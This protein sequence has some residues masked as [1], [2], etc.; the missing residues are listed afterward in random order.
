MKF[1][2]RVSWSN[3]TFGVW[4]SSKKQ[5]PFRRKIALGIEL[6]PLYLGWVWG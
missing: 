1:E 2:K 5:V 3:W 6:G 4:W